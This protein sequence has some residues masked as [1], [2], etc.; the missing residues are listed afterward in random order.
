[1][2][3]GGTLI[4]G[5]VRDA[6]TGLPLANV[7][8]SF[9]RTPESVYQ[10]LA[11]TLLTAADG[12]YAIDSSF[13]NES[14]LASG[15]TATIKVNIGGYLGTQASFSFPTGPVT[16]D[17]NLR[18]DNG[19]LVTGIVTDRVTHQPIPYAQVFFYGTAYG[20][21]TADADG[22][23]SISSANLTLLPGAITGGIFV[24]APGYYEA[25]PT[26][27]PDLSTQSSLPLV[28]DIS[29]QPGGTVIQGTVRDA[30]TGLPLA[31]VYVSFERE[32]TSNYQELAPSV[33]T[34]ADGTYTFDSVF[35]NESALTSGFTA[36]IKVNIDGYWGA[37]VSLSF[38]GPVTQDFNLQPS[39]P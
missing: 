32:P 38:T 16:Q 12:T 13:F 2:Q 25:G 27:I 35:F 9:E 1:L 30:N 19:P 10:G 11:P 14:G 33:F 28:A 31:N 34:A 39:P 5:T 18:A 17:F 23:Y 7:A 20:I 22:R 21:V 24:G 8:I 15:F 26:V 6:S 37:Q 29:L 3:P 4:Q 36:T